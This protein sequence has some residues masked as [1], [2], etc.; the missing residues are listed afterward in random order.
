M[1]IVTRPVADADD[2]TVG[3]DLPALA[4]DR[5]REHPRRCIHEVAGICRGRPP[6]AR[7]RT[8]PAASRF[9][10]RPIERFRILFSILAANTRLGYG[11]Q[12][13]VNLMSSWH[14]FMI[15]GAGRK[16]RLQGS[17]DA[18]NCLGTS[19]PWIEFSTDSRLLIHTLTPDS[20]PAFR[21]RIRRTG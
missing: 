11:L 1:N 18:T 5:H 7:A 2:R 6:R 20:P 19:C 16:L 12:F 9:H 15:H 10:P 4:T 21:L 13:P 3:D 8:A 17:L 14:L